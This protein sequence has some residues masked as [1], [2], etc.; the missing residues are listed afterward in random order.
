MVDYA[1]SELNRITD[2]CTDK[3]SK[4]MQEMINNDIIEIIEVFSKQG[5]SGFSANY[6]ISILTKLLSG[7]PISVL[8]GEYDEWGRCIWYR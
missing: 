1:K 5:H 6:A 3:D 7:K 4:E 8:T 2:K